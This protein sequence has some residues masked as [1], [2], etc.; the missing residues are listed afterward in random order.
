M[1]TR[2]F[3]SIFS[4]TRID[5]SPSFLWQ[6]IP[7]KEHIQLPK[8]YW[9]WPSPKSDKTYKTDDAAMNTPENDHL[10]QELTFEQLGDIDTMLC[11]IIV[12]V[13]AALEFDMDELNIQDFTFWAMKSNFQWRT[14]QV[15]GS[16]HD[17]DMHRARGF[18]FLAS[19]LQKI[20]KQ[21]KAINRDDPKNPPLDPFHV[22]QI[23]YAG[24][25]NDTWRSS[26]I[27]WMLQSC[28]VIQMA[29][30]LILK[31]T[32]PWTTLCHILIWDEWCYGLDCP[33]LGWVYPRQQVGW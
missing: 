15:C 16:S 24:P 17:S 26:G 33:C 5:A 28:L 4:P 25:R 7:I 14:C 2:L 3:N 10:D 12:P 6:Q 13:L 29:L 18:D 19:W 11:D 32:S 31:V 21:Y 27:H 8:F 23:S 22:K 20:V 1:F 30:T 9:H